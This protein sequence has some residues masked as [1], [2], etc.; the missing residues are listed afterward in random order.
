MSDSELY[1]LSDDDALLIAATQQVES[2]AA[3]VDFVTSPRPRKRQCTQDRFDDRSSEG[4]IPEDGLLSDDELLESGDVQAESPNRRQRLFHAPRIQANLEHVIISQT[5]VVP[6]SQPWQ[7]RGPVWKKPK[8]MTPEKRCSIASYFTN[9]QK[10]E[11]IPR[12]G[13]TKN[14]AQIIATS[15]SNV[16]RTNS[17]VDYSSAFDLTNLP[18]DAFASSPE[19]RSGT[20]VGVRAPMNGLRQTTLFGG[21]NADAPLSQVNKRRN[22]P[23]ANQ[24]EPPTHH[25]VDREAMKTWIYPTN[26]GKI[27]DYQFNIVHRGLFHNLLVALPTGLGKTFIAATIMLN[28][29]RW[30]RSAQIIFVAPTKPLVAQQVEACFNIA[31]IPRSQTT[32]LTGEVNAGLRAEEWEK[33]R[34]FFMTPQTLINDLKTGICDPKRVVLLVIDE[35]HRATGNYAYVEVVKFIRRFNE[36]FRILA[37]TATPG[38]EVESVQKVI[39]GLDIARCEIRTEKSFDIRE[40]VHQKEITKQV[41]Q[42]NEEMELLF[43][44]FSK[45]AQP[46]L[47]V[48]NAQNAYYVKDPLKISRYGLLLAQREWSK[49][50]AGRHAGMAVKGMLASAFSVL[51]SLAFALELLKYYSI[52][53]FYDQLLKMRKEARAS[54]SKYRKQIDESEAME[55]M[56]VRLKA[57]HSDPEFVGHPKLEQVR[58]EVLQHLI[59][60]GEGANGGERTSTRIEIF[61]QYRESVEEICRVLK[62]DA[63]IVRP[64]VFVGQSSSE[65]SEG[66]TQKKQLEVTQKFKTG[67]FNVLISTQVGEEGLDIGELDLIICYDSKSSPIRLLQRMGR[68]GRKREGRVVWL[69][70][71]G[72]EQ[73]DAIKAMD[74]YEKMQEL[75]AS[76]DR[77]NFHHDRSRRIVPKDIQPVVDKRAVEIPVENTQRTASDFLPVP[78]KK[79]RGKLPKRPPKKFHMPDGVVTGFTNVSRLGQA[80][81]ILVDEAESIPL[82]HDVFLSAQQVGDLE[83]LYQSVAGGDDDVIITPPA[84]NKHPVA[85]RQLRRTNTVKHSTRC[86]EFVLAMSRIAKIDANTVEEQER[87]VDAAYLE[88]ED[89]GSTLVEERLVK[90]KDNIPPDESAPRRGRP[91]GSKN[92]AVRGGGL[93]RKGKKN[94]VVGD[95]ISD[96]EGE[97]SSGLHT[98]PVM[99]VRSQAI[100]LGS[101]DTEESEVED[102]YVDSDLEDFVVDDDQPLSQVDSSLPSPSKMLQRQRQKTRRPSRVSLAASSQELPELGALLNCTA[103]NMQQ[104]RQV[105]VVLEEA[106]EK[107]EVEKES[108][109]RGKKTGKRRRIVSDDEDE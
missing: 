57:W 78:T 21:S 52:K 40:Y 80:T 94:K 26:L 62:K 27:R 19:S 2:Q 46:M 11:S 79:G 58:A 59:D 82:L 3:E 25:E 7:I 84:L 69:Q 85:Q 67:E 104:A 92:K 34:V 54:K 20:A 101:A 83:R 90:I 5:Q 53:A 103:V 96:T 13:H 108:K 31:G 45:V 74:N 14:L 29:Y 75:I 16:S 86:K 24:D 22:W 71:E 70:M 89:V 23:L 48:V 109:Q 36:S 32:M 81:G 64:H 35:A 106:E 49:S 65:K 87:N 42:P 44:W 99:Q 33:K 30:T 77:F 47:D 18:S 6:P 105:S 37:L 12:Q 95:D 100:T 38:S 55:R 60:A 10:P 61:S 63:P 50:N 8:D 98:S 107:S 73:D 72:K 41:F 102:G 17:S 88:P 91:P 4:N 93:A 9:E 76:G 68:T 97:P 43:E 66:M 1:G 28:F 15:N 51:Q 39:D 56:M